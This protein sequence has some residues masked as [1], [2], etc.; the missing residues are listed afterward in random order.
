MDSK[1]IWVSIE[2]KQASSS[3]ESQLVLY[4]PSFEYIPIARRR[5]YYSNCECSSRGVNAFSCSNNEKVHSSVYLMH[6]TFS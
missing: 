2:R 1:E 3:L 4:M 6:Q 5:Y